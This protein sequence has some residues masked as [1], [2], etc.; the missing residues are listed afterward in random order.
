MKRIVG[1]EE[2]T[3][4]SES[5]RAP[6]RVSEGKRPSATGRE[7]E[8]ARG[9]AL[10]LRHP[11][12]TPMPAA[13]RGPSDDRNALGMRHPGSVPMPQEL[14]RTVAVLDSARGG[15]VERVLAE[16]GADVAPARR[17]GW[18]ISGR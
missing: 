9:S 8:G 1:R 5:R 12:I 11:A 15:A 4:R 18:S 2:F 3:E 10:G 7:R 13:L 14:R 16:L 6:A 17:G